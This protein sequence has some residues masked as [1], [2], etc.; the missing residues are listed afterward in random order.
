[1]FALAMGVFWTDDFKERS[2]VP[3]GSAKQAKS[4]IARGVLRAPRL[5]EDG[6]ANL[7]QREKDT[8]AWQLSA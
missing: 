1:M 7:L 8:E 3:T 2:G 4:Y 5:V 6:L